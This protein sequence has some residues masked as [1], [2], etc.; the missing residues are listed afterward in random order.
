VRGN[1]RQT[2]GACYREVRMRDI[3]MLVTHAA[4]SDRLPAS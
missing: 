1:S 3:T 4:A 2:V